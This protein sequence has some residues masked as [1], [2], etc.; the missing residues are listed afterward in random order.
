VKARATLVG[1]LSVRISRLGGC[2]EEPIQV[3]RGMGVQTA[4]P[5]VPPPAAELGA[6]AGVDAG[7]A[8]PGYRDEDFVEADTNRDPFRNY[9]AMFQA[10][11]VAE[12]TTRD[13]K[14]PE[15]SIDE[16][17]LIAI[18]SGVADPRAMLVDRDGVGHVVRRGN[19]IG[20]PEIVQ[21]GGLEELAVTLHWR[22]DRIRPNAVVLTRDDPT[23]P[24]RPPLTRVLPLREEDEDLQVG[25]L[26]PR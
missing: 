2:D 11:P 18:V 6:D 16:M 15:T 4:P 20:R 10:G 26:A 3:G 9:A 22:V 13:V 7:P 1:V 5:A 25:A 24:N 17:R 14:M 23:A 12:Q 19:F 21:A 8:Q